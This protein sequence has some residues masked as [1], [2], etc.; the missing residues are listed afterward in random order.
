[1]Q[2]FFHPRPSNDGMSPL[3][4]YVLASSQYVGTAKIP[5]VLSKSLWSKGSSMLCSQIQSKEWLGIEESMANEER[6]E[7]WGPKIPRSFQLW[8]LEKMF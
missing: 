6:S 2:S 1:M 5:E 4:D 7:H 3:E 8:C